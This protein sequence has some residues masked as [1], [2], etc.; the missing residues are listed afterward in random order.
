M[1]IIPKKGLV[2]LKVADGVPVVDEA[3]AQLLGFFCIISV[4][5]GGKI[6][7]CLGKGFSGSTL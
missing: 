1:K 3:T 5:C 6:S 2:P 7:R 4:Y